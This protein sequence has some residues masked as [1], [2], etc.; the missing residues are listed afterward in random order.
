M[1]KLIVE[2]KNDTAF[3]QALVKH[4]NAH[5]EVE[6]ISTILEFEDLGV[7]L[8][9]QR[10][11]DKISDVLDE[12]R[13]RDIQKIGVLIDLD[14]ETIENRIILVN[15][16]LKKALFDKGFNENTEGVTSINAFSNIKIDEV[17][18][19][20][21][22]CHFTNVEGEGEL[23]TVLKKIK[24]QNS[25]YADCLENWR[26]CLTEKGKSV[27][28]KEFDKFWINNYIRFDTCKNKEKGQAERK[29][30]MQNFDY[31]LEKS[32]FNFDDVILNDLKI[33]LN[34]FN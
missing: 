19:I 30:S 28:D 1:N 21:F 18:N 34:L 4:I 13:K 33:F 9:E 26:S 14:K 6:E 8:S 3:V 7:G 10:L 31:V 27:S 32:I 20:E 15:K 25:D 16:C 5:A 12:V 2:S 11:T 22:A 23:E 29:C 17:I 24:N